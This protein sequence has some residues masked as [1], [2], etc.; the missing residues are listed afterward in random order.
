MLGAS[1]IQQNQELWN[2]AAEKGIFIATDRSLSPRRTHI[3]NMVW[4]Q[5]DQERN[6]DKI[7]EEAENYSNV[8][9]TFYPVR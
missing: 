7:I 9:P 6:V 1:P 4:R 8:L 3:I 2:Q 5:Y